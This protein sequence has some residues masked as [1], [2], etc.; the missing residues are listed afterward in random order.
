MSLRA[1]VWA[2]RVG[3]VELLTPGRQVAM[4]AVG[5]GW[6]RARQE[7][8][9]GVDY[10]F[11]LDGGAPLPDPRSHSQPQG[12]S[13]PSRVVDHREFAWTDRRWAGLHLPS[14]V[15]YE[16]HVGTFSGPGTFFG[17]IEHLDHLVALGVNAIEIMPI[18]AFDGER[19]WGYDGVSLYAVHEPYGGPD[20][21]KRLV[22]AAH[23][24]GLGVVL[25]VVYNHFGP[26]GNHLGEFGPYTSDRHQTPWGDAVNLDGPDSAPVRRYFLDNARHWFEHYHVDALRLDA[27]H[28]LIDES[29]HHFLAELAEETEALS[30]HL[31]RPLWLVAE[32]PTTTPIGVSSADAGGHGLDAEWRDELHHS[33][34]AWLTGERSGYYAEYGSVSDLAEAVTGPKEPLPR[35]RFV[36]C[37]QNHDQV[38]NRAKGDRLCHLVDTGRA[39]IAAAL[40]LLSPFVPL[41]FM[42]EEWAASS[43]FPYFAGP[44]NPDLDDAVRNG[45]RDEF[46]AF[47]WDPESI[48][49]PIARSTFDAAHLR[50]SELDQP[51][52]AS[53]IEWYRDLIALRRSR[54]ELSDPRPA[55]T[56]IDEHDSEHTVVMWRGDTAVAVN[57]DK[58]P[59]HVSLDGTS[60]TR[61]L[62]ASDADVR[63]TG[64]GVVLPPN[65]VAVVGR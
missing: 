39:K 54:P 46:A 31:R 59:V 37:A 26:T 11:R 41:L 52:H 10:G 38:G 13:S 55:S 25:D 28:A 12:P 16:L 48:P 33:V 6:F 61:V 4:D 63:L 58:Q 19:G 24:R 18:A 7:L 35:S 60:D 29:D 49:D 34:H 65:S 50:W 14:A 15:I 51:A 56:G 30:A 43:P 42:G 44:R 9:A 47:G 21:F 2:P 5:D 17:V 27:V 1:E 64:N 57:T 36:V 40:V 20:A 45:R 23:A 3:A 53:M 8:D 22:D 62:L 32:Y